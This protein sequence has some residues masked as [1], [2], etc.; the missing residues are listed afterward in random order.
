MRLLFKAG[1]IHED[2]YS[3]IHFPNT[4]VIHEFF[5]AHFRQTYGL[6]M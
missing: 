1:L 5:D 6:V 3:K 4:L 2:P